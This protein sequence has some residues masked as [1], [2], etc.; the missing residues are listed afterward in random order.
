MRPTS[1][2]EFS[3]F[4]LVSLM[5]LVI[6]FIVAISSLGFAT[7]ILL[8]VAILVIVGG[9]SAWSYK[10]FSKRNDT[11]LKDVVKDNVHPKI[12]TKEVDETLAILD[13]AANF[14]SASLKSDDMFRLIASR[15]KEVIPHATAVF[16]KADENNRLSATHSSGKNS[17][18][19]TTVVLECD[20]GI[21]GKAFVSSAIEVDPDLSYEKRFLDK[22][23]LG[24]NR[25][26]IAAPL[27][28][29]VE[30]YGVL[31]LY[32]EKFAER[33]R[34]IF[35]ALSERISPLL[36]SSFSFEES[37]LNSM[38]DSL[39]NL[40][41]ERA[42]Y[43]VLENQI[44]EALRFQEQRPLTILTI[45]I[46]GFADFNRTYGHSTGDSL[47]AFASEIISGQLR[48]MDFLCRS[49]NDEFW[50]VLPTASK[51]VTKKIIS[52]IEVAFFK[53][54]FVLNESDTY[55]PEMNFG[56]A[57]FLRDGETTNHLLQKALL[58][59][60]QKKEGSESSVIMFPK[61]YV[62]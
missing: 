38:V 9:V 23:L 22:K 28:R 1:V 16:Y 7:K 51:E 27:K 6:T 49:M 32:G 13:E 29:G 21:A 24:E 35:E 17:R 10:R 40:P 31:V 50:V 56:S 34:T 62:N 26:A 15:T 53:S 2:K 60:K 46:R 4:A 47:L 3:I 59:K 5:A 55:S 30:T 19:I 61:E 20:E 43:L 52:R 44:A 54:A 11:S 45:D 57:T 14:F 41:N 18:Q 12:F 8:F 36:A 39:T 42:F 48:D 58:R 33:E 25:S 37:T